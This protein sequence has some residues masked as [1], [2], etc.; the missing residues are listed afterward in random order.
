[1]ETLSSSVVEEAWHTLHAG[2]ADIRGHDLMETLLRE[3]PV[4]LAFLLSAEEDL[5]QSAD[6]QGFITLNG[7]WIWLAFRLAGRD[8]TAVTETSLEA[9]YSAN[10]RQMHAMENVSDVMTAGQSFLADYRQFPLMSHLLHD[11]MGDP[12]DP[13]DR[14]VDD[15]VGQTILIYKTVI[16]VLDA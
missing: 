10:V 3:Q 7:L 6:D 1:M 9:A 15:V 4:L 8:T 16:D 11:L 13:L 12:H 5:A 14:R 2:D